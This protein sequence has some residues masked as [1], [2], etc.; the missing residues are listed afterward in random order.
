MLYLNISY[1][2]LE[3]VLTLS[4]KP[5]ATSVDSLLSAFNASSRYLNA[6]QGLTVSPQVNRSTDA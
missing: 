1:A 2:P 6:S 4:T 5:L 3:K